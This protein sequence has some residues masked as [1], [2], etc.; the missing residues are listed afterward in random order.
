MYPYLKLDKTLLTVV[1][2]LSLFAVS[3]IVVNAIFVWYL[4]SQN[5]FR[6]LWTVILLRLT[7]SAMFGPLY[8]PCLSLL[9]T[10]LV[11][12]DQSNEGFPCWGV[13]HSMLVTLA[14]LFGIML[15]LI[16]LVFQATYYNLL[17]LLELK[18]L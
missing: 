16:A 12:K 11:C 2:V 18:Q 13:A 6:M 1:F 3:V 4:F 15:I 5:S 10:Q 8:I 9:A 17:F 7:A 14:V